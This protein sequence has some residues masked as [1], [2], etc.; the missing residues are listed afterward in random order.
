MSKFLKRIITFTGIA[1]IA[2]Q[3]QAAAQGTNNPISKITIA[4]PTAASLGKYGDIPVN[5]HTGIPQISI[6]I[7]TA[8]AGPLSLPVSLSYHASGLKVQEPASWVGAGWALNSG[9]VITRSVMGAPDEKGTNNGGTQTHG[10][11]SDYGYNSYVNSGGAGNT[12]TEDWQAIANG[13]KDGE[14]DLFFFNFGSYSGKF[15]FRDDRTPVIV[16]E[17]DFKIEPYYN[18]PNAAPVGTS[19]SIQSFIITTPDGVKYY[20]GNTPGL[21]GTPPV[22]IT[23]PVTAANGMSSANTISSWFLNKVSTADDQFAITLSYQPENYGYHT[24]SMFPID[25]VPANQ[26]FGAVHGYDLVKNVIQGVRLSQINFGNGNGIINFITGANART[27]LSDNTGLFNS[28]PVNQSAK[29]LAAIEITDG[30]T[31]VKKFN[32]TYSYFTDNS[33]PLPQDIA[34]FAPTLQTDKQR[35]KLDQVQEISGDGTITKPAHYFTYFNEQ[36]PRRLSFGIDHWGFSNGATGN[37]TPIPTYTVFQSNITNNYPGANRDASWPAMRGGTLQQ[38]NYPTGGYSLFEFEPNS[39]YN[40]NTSNVT[41]NV[42]LT[43]LYVHLYGQS[44]LSMT[45]SFV[46]DGTAMSM[47]FNNASNYSSPFTIVN[48]SN[49]V[50]YTTNIG[51][52]Q[53]VTVNLTLPAGTY[54]ATLSVHPSSTG[55]SQVAINQWQTNPVTTSNTIIIGGNHIKTITHNDGVTTNNIVTAYDYIQD[56]NQ[57][58]AILYSRPAYVGIIRNDLIRDVGYWTTNGFTPYL[59]LN[60]CTTV[61]NASYYKSPSSIRPMATTQGNHIGYSQV[62]VSQTGNGYSVYKYYG[63]T[64]VAPWQTNSGPIA[65]QSI[66]TAGCDANAPNYPAAPLPFDYKRGELQYEAHYNQANQL[67]KEA[68]YTP[69]YVNSSITTPGFIVSSY[70]N[71]GGFGAFLATKYELTTARKT[72]TQVTETAYDPATGGSSTTTNTSY[73]ESAFHNQA[74]R[75]TSTN[76]QGVVVETKMKYAFDF[77]ISTCDGIADG[78]PQYTIDCATCLTAKNNAMAACGNINTNPNYNQCLT[79]A[80]LAYLQCQT[81]ARINYVNYRKTNFTNPVNTFKTYHDNAKNNPATDAELK[82]ILQL[83]DNY[84]NPVIET[85]K[86]K[87]GN[88]LGASFSRYDYST[89]PAG[90]VYINKV[91]AINLAATTTTF[92]NAA[93]N[94]ANTGIIKDSRYKDESFVKFYNGNLAEIT[95]KDA[96]T[97]AYLWGY[98]NTLPIAKSIGVT[99]STLL[100]A[101][102][103]AGNNLSLLRSQPAL[104]VNGAQLNTYVYT[105]IVG[106]TSETDVNGKSITYEYDKLQRLLLARDFNNNILKQYDYKYQVTPPNATPQWLATGL[107]RCKPCPQNNIYITN[108]LQQEEKDNNPASG[109][110]NNLRWTDIGTS[111]ACVSDANWQNTAI[112]IRCRLNASSQNTGEQEQQQSDINP[113]SPTYGLTQWVVVGINTTA[114]PLP[115][116]GCNTSNCTGADKKCIN[117]LCETG[118]RVN[119]ATVQNPKLVGGWTCTYHYVWSDG[120]ISVDY[121]EVNASA[122][123]ILDF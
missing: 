41:S 11:F 91:Q 51:N 19:Y 71:T 27:D 88:L 100:A 22:E 42:T 63:P 9:G 110:Y 105:P 39:V 60:G 13:Y 53:V 4:S 10:H 101:Y 28:D 112:A 67:L 74:T 97:T 49:V 80:Y 18:P 40:T 17:A 35:L 98:N 48:S 26:T 77:R 25:A 70:T 76:S 23:K 83:Q 8:S 2:V 103:T 14:P 108:I 61:G 44:A 47:S 21:T 82:P 99:H 55:G 104:N 30:I 62:K 58:S 123:I 114:C 56:N 102:G 122:C 86:W 52:N 121:T 50:V 115:V 54:Q 37:S 20:F 32:F 38:I 75:A 109:T 59:S 1:L 12:G 7:Y 120:S 36:V 69:V 107:T 64:G 79:D 5:Y 3:Q 29:P 24:I 33:T 90:K 45:N 31:A 111:T 16:P 113:C 34:N 81:T 106:M 84:E 43:S 46:T 92:T 116:S 6:P 72:Q 119:T 66:N 95:S 65:V 85:T 89:V 117:G 96:V 68:S 78:Y 93:T 73:N 94:A 15:Y 118:T 57:T 87:N